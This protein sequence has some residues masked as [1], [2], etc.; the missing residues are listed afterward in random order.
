[1]RTKK[2][3]GVPDGVPDESVEQTQK[4]LG[5]ARAIDCL[6]VTIQN[7]N[8]LLNRVK[9]EKVDE[10]E[11]GSNQEMP[12]VVFLDETETRVERMTERLEVV[13]EGFL[14]ALF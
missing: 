5:I 7:L 6:E 12:L 8:Y 3:N 9:G 2:T 11:S 10:E 13:C 1:M 14:K 4:H